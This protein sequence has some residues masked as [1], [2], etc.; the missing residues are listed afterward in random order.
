MSVR[1]ALKII[2]RGLTGKGTYGNRD[3]VLDPSGDAPTVLA[4][5][6]IKCPPPLVMVRRIENED[7]D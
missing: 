1:Y 2:G 5:W 7:S 6:G 3:L 4:N